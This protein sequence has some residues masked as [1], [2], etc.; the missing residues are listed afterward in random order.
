MPTSTAAA[1]PARSIVATQTPKSMKVWMHLAW[2]R[3][4]GR[5]IFWPL[6]PVWS[7]WLGYP[8]PT[9]GLC[10]IALTIRNMLQLGAIV[11]PKTFVIAV[12]NQADLSRSICFHYRV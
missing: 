7:V 5:L 4:D 8:D 1:G 10:Y 9:I 6:H 2:V 11:R 3:I 12:S